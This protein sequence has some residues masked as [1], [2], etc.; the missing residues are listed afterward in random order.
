MNSILNE[1]ALLRP[2]NSTLSNNHRSTILGDLAYRIFGIGLLLALYTVD[3]H[4]Y[5]HT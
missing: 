3:L 4:E 1:P 5:V 2:T